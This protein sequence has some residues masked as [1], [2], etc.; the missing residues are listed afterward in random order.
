M[1]DRIREIL[2]WYRSKSPG[3]LTHLSRI[4]SLERLVRSRRMINAYTSIL[5]FLE[6]RTAG[7]AGQIPLFTWNS[8]TILDLEKD[9]PGSKTR[10]GQC[11][12]RKYGRC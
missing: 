6:T 3:V 7:F 10:T 4:L 9:P 8:H 2:G 5:G 11:A 1:N 12:R